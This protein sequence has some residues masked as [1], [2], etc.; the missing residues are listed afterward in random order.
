MKLYARLLFFRLVTTTLSYL[1]ILY[2]INFLLE[3]STHKSSLTLN[4]CMAQLSLRAELFLPLSIAWGSCYVYYQMRSRSETIAL[5]SAGISRA[6]ILTPLHIL[7]LIA[8]ALQLVN[9]YHGIDRALLHKHTNTLSYKARCKD[10]SPLFFQKQGTEYTHIF[11]IQNPYT[12]HA[13]SSDGIT[14]YDVTCFYQQDDHSIERIAHFAT[15]PL[16]PHTLIMDNTLKHK[17]FQ[18]GWLLSPLLLVY[19]FA[20]S[21]IAHKPTH[22]L[23]SFMTLQLALFLSLFFLLKAYTLYSSA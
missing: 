9:V 16:P 21:L 2:F 3:L 5:L 18:W 15:Y 6:Q 22:P 14:A 10:Q 23:L 19:P 13:T 12:W 11:W 1:S 8:S 4:W 7:L 20:F 17:L